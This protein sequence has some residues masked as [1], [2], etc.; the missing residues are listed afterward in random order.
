M[1]RHP[2]RVLKVIKETAD[3]RT[4][5]LSA[6][7]S[8][9]PIIIPGQY[10]ILCF[11]TVSGEKRRSYSITDKDAIGNFSI[12]VKN[13]INGEFSRKLV[14]TKPGEVLYADDITG[15]FTSPDI[16]HER[17]AFLFIAAGSGITACIRLIEYLLHSSGNQ[18]FLLYQNR[19]KKETIFLDRLNELQEK[20]KDRFIIYYLF[21][22]SGTADHTRL[23]PDLLRRLLHFYNLQAYHQTWAYV[24]G[25]WE[26][27]KMCEI[28]L[29]T[30]LPHVQFRKEQYLELP[31]INVPTPPDIR[32]HEVRLMKKEEVFV[33][34]SAYPQT[35]LESATAAGIDLPFSCQGG[36]CGA[37]TVQC[38]EGEIWMSYNE[39][40]TEEDVQSGKRLICTG[41]PIFGNV[42]I[43]R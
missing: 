11:D 14:N 30:W 41:Y 7:D 35:I 39:V 10:I 15:Q 4:L 31:R 43:E 9:E 36:I 26:F 16:I 17:D 6:L 37:C 1:N 20:F 5:W 32:M 19:S 34:S 40:L 18:L 12:T 33:F 8:W 3:S 21:S 23:G 29:H 25:P 38:T 42:S 27:M 13:I 2:L 22:N 24:C 28:T